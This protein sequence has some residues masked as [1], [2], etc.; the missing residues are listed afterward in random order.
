MR[1]R[2]FYAD[3]WEKTAS[4]W[5]ALD[6]FLSKNDLGVESDTGR[7]KVGIGQKWANTPYVATTIT[8]GLADVLV[9]LPQDGDVLRWS[10]GRWRNYPET[11]VTDGGNF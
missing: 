1:D 11:N 10:D 8:I 7:I 3:I 9:T 6:P 4:Q 5:A 2:E